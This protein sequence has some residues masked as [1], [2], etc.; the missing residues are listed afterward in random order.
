MEF[1]RKSRRWVSLLLPVSLSPSSVII[2]CVYTVRC[3][4]HSTELHVISSYT[5]QYS[6]YSTHSV[7][8]YRVAVVYIIVLCI[9]YRFEK[10]GNR[11][12]INGLFHYIE[13]EPHYV[14]YII[15]YICIFYRFVDGRL[16]GTL[17]W[18]PAEIIT[19][20]AV[21]LRIFGILF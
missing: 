10:S 18:Y 4:I 13:S 6:L 1:F 7:L 12:F 14:Q 8:G 20:S 19:I 16:L 21:I 17:P 11:F 15:K 9:V 3:C 5:V 2:V